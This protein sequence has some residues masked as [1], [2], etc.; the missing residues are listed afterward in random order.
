M[1][2]LQSVSIL[3]KAL[4]SKASGRGLRTVVLHDV[5]G[6]LLSTLAAMHPHRSTQR[7]SALL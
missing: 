5:E 3:D 6:V 1:I 2:A 4:L 7:L